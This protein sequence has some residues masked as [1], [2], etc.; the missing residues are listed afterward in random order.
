M[1]T[2]IVQLIHFFF[3]HSV[4]RDDIQKMLTSHFLKNLCVLKMLLKVEFDQL[5]LMSGISLQARH[6][7]SLSFIRMIS[8]L[9]GLT[10]HG[11]GSLI[12]E[13]QFKMF[14][15]P[16]KN[17]NET[18]DISKHFCPKMPNSAKIGA[19]HYIYEIQRSVTH[20]GHR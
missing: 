7:A 8:C 5:C 20:M 18:C 2:C 14:C 9:S 11:K 19:S 10:I 4:H 12:T 16:T 6:Q 15:P 13:V 1:K 17:G 3:Q